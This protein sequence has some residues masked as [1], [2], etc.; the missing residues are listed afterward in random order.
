MHRFGGH[1]NDLALSSKTSAAVAA[2][3][4]HRY[5]YAPFCVGAPTNSPES[6]P[7]TLTLP[8]SLPG[9]TGQSSTHGRWLLD[10]QSKS[11]VSDFDHLIVPKSGRPDF[12][13][14]RAKT[15]M[16][17]NQNIGKQRGAVPV[18]EVSRPQLPRRRPRQRAHC[19]TVIS[20]STCPFGSLK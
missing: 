13:S 11:D 19:G 20:S 3:L 17:W 15:M 10:R 9:L 16:G 14:S 1:V 8:V 18:L 4:P 7:V 12:G 2:M 5:V 6:F